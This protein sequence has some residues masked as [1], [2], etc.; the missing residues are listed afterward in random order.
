L[1]ISSSVETIGKDAFYI[2][3]FY[4]E[5]GNPLPQSASA[6][7]GHSFAGNGDWKLYRIA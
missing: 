2:L 4:D 5:D 6:L 3:Y 1:V 7:S